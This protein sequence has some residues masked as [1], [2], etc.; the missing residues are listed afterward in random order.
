[1][2]GSDSFYLFYIFSSKAGLQSLH[3]RPSQRTII[4]RY[5]GEFN[6][7]KIKYLQKNDDKNN[8]TVG[9]RTLSVARS[10]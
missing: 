6:E 1:M 4:K 9:R 3:D 10:T 8:D 5:C 7:L 2:A